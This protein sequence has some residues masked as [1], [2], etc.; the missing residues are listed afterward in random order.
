MTSL[1]IGPNNSSDGEPDPNVVFDGG[2]YTFETA[3]VH[4]GALTFTGDAGNVDLG[5]LS[6]TAGVTNVSGGNVYA[7]KIDV[8]GSGKLA[9]NGGSLHTYTDQIFVAGVG[10]DGQKVNPEGVK[11]GI[12]LTKGTV[13]F[14]DQFYNEF[15]KNNAIT[16]AKDGVSVVFN[17]ERVGLN[18]G[19]I[20]IDDV[21]DQEGGS[22]R[23]NGVEL[24]EG[25][26]NQRLTHHVVTVSDGGDTVGADLRL[27]DRRSQIDDTDQNTG[28]QNGCALR[29]RRVGQ[30]A[31][32]EEEADEAVEALRTGERRE[33]HVATEGVAV[34]LHG[35]DRS[36]AC[37]GRSDGGCD[38][39]QAHHQRYAD[40]SHYQCCCCFHS[41]L[42]SF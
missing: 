34:L 28:T 7:D 11:N 12:E 35:T 22:N 8:S 32:H 27:I 37:D 2:S 31:L 18:G 30:S 20:S 33:D 42:K 25:G 5:T 39:R 29:H 41:V 24:R 3:S 10:E 16:L 9:V 13:A 21:G 38:A 36:H 17:G 23:Q 1:A 40:V 6:I 14:E 26:Q 15:Y 19:T 4:A